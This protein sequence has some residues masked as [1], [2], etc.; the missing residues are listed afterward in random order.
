MQRVT[1]IVTVLIA[2][3]TAIGSASAQT[4]HLEDSLQDGST[5]GYLVG[6]EFTPSGWTVTN[7]T[8][9]ADRIY[10]I[11]P[12]LVSGYVQFT[13]SNITQDNLDRNDHDIF[14]MYEGGFGLETTD[15]PI[16]Y[17]PELRLNN[18]RAILRVFG[19][20]ATDPAGAALQGQQELAL[21]MCSGGSPGHSEPC[22]CGDSLLEELR[23]GDT[24]WNG[25][26]QVIRIEWGAGVTRYAR[27]G[28]DVFE[29]PWDGFSFGPHELHISF[30]TPRPLSVD[31]A[32][33]PTG[34]VFSDLIVEGLE[35]AE[36]GCGGP[37]APDGGVDAGG[38]DAQGD[39]GGIL[40]PPPPP[41][42]GDG[43]TSD[44][45]PGFGAATGSEGCACGMAGPAEEQNPISLLAFFL[46]V[47]VRFN[48]G[49]NA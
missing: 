13:V 15:D 49:A 7:R 24:A 6:G 28:I 37:F 43:G 8:N 48:R 27:N 47:F 22:P 12:R 38:L 17:D 4:F 31:T 20:K 9:R 14:A 34:A 11:L 3:L 36:Q 40:P 42:R 32:S 25:S 39:G 30:G 21:R 46:V 44:A 45:L 26:P 19:R 18:S 10:W 2:S 35:G 41:P 23:G 16:D 1:T 33:M 29:I 5:S